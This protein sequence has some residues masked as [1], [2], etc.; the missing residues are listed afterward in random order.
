VAPPPL[1]V[2]PYNWL[3]APVVFGAIAWLLDRKRVAAQSRT[4]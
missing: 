4:A 1:K 3:I 2:L